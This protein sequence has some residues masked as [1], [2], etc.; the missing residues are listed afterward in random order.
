MGEDH[1]KLYFLRYT[2]CSQT[3]SHGVG[4]SNLNCS[5][6]AHPDIDTGWTGDDENFSSSQINESLLECSDYDPADSGP[7]SDL[8]R[9]IVLGIGICI[10]AVL[11][12]SKTSTLQIFNLHVLLSL[13][14]MNIWL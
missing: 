3:Q 8:F 4:G 11:G 13:S 9:F 2:N 5:W 14:V 12:M 10:V 1:D 7:D 6:M